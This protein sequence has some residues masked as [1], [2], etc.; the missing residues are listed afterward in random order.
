[1]HLH[2]AISLYQFAA[3]P[4]VPVLLAGDLCFS[5]ISGQ[6]QKLLASHLF[7]CCCLVHLCFSSALSASSASP[8][9][10]S[11]PFSRRT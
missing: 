7:L 11:K 1:M 9:S 5:S 2:M 8:A 6:R 4:L 10:S 3:Q